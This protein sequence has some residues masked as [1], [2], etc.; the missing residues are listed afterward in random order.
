MLTFGDEAVCVDVDNVVS[1]SMVSVT[2]VPD[3]A[4]TQ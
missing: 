1:K 3:T 4:M 2:P